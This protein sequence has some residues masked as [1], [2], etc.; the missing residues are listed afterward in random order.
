MLRRGRD[1]VDVALEHCGGPSWL[2]CSKV[3]MSLK[4]DVLS[5]LKLSSPL[6]LRFIDEWAVRSFSFTPFVASA[7]CLYHV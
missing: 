2:T 7:H 6:L 3:S 5:F 1:G 4:L